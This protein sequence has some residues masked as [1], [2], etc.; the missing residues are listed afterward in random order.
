MLVFNASPLIVSVKAGLME[1]FIDLWPDLVIPEAVA[2]EVMAR[3]HE[4]DPASIWLNEFARKSCRVTVGAPNP[5]IAAWDLGSGESA[6]LQCCMD[7]PGAMA[8]LDDF[9]AR[10]CAQSCGIPVTGTVGLL[11][12]SAKKDPAFSLGEAIQAIQVAGLYLS[13]PLIKQI[14]SHSGRSTI[15]PD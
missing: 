5:F 2:E 7:R 13:K 10:K 1:R 3:G 4:D 11:L 15:Q 6:V 12:Q 8:V 14:L 9:A